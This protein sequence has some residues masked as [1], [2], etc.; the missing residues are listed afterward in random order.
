M[1]RRSAPWPPPPHDPQT[2]RDWDRRA[3]DEYGMPSIILMENAGREA[4]RILLEL[5]AATPDRYHAPWLVLSGGGN[6]GGDGFV[7]AR[8]LYNAGEDVRIFPA[9]RPEH[10]RPG[11]DNT[12]NWHIVE[13]MRIPI[14]RVGE[15]L[16]PPSSLEGAQSGVI[17]D[18][19]LGTG[20]RPPLRDPIDEW[21][22]TVRRIPLPVVALDL[23][24]GLDAATGEADEAAIHAAH[25]IT[26]A[27][28]KTGFEREDARRYTG[29]VHVVDIGLPR[30]LWT[31]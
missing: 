21:T 29:E 26:F 20:A 14:E 7:V 2:I 1:E 12:T 31:V 4:A 10:L 18:A 27:A 30:G 11:A 22:R 17:V 24:T 16:D 19:L 6:N 23:P 28:A 25:T 5:A 13:R 15:G 3:T 8:H 9:F